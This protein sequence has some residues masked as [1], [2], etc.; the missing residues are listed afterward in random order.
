MSKS[1]YESEPP[2][3][4]VYIIPI[5]RKNSSIEVYLSLVEKCYYR[6]LWAERTSPESLKE[7]MITTGFY[8]QKFE[9]L[10]DVIFPE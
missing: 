2:N 3:D 4:L 8:Y 9:T 10:E 6:E 1:T 5:H 7:V